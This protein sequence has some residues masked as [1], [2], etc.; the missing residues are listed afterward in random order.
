MA[1]E[2]DPTLLTTTTAQTEGSTEKETQNSEGDKE[3]EWG[4]FLDQAPDEYKKHPEL[5]G[6]ATLGDLI[7]EHLDIKS[8][9]KDL[10][11]RSKDFIQKPG[12]DAKPEDI[13]RY[14]EWRG[15]PKDA[16]G[17][18][19]VPSEGFRSMAGA[20][21]T[22]AFYKDT[23][24]QAGLTPDEASTAWSKVESKIVGALKSQADARQ[25][26]RII[27]ETTI[28]E[29]WKGDFD[30]K[31]GSIVELSK[32]FYSP[33]TWAKIEAA[34]LGNDLAFLESQLPIAKAFGEGKILRGGASSQKEVSGAK[35]VFSGEAWK[36]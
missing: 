8:K 26:E 12:K 18:E 5:K 34:G 33:E 17:Y 7:K 25:Q 11:A 27:G 20:D 23:F 29:A 4:K 19:I 32:K 2:I 10:E 6:K 21:G 28:K 24:L 35:R 9:A 31:M 16:A 13:Q 30:K 1:E 15:V 22:L 36:A 14:R 3:G